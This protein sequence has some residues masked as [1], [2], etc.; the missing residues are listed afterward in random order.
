MTDEIRRRYLEVK[1][2]LFALADS[3]LNPAQREAVYDTEG[4]LLVFA[5]AGS[6]KTTVLVRRV[7]QIIRY[8]CGYRSEKVPEDVSLQT[9]EAY[10]SALDLS[11]EDVR[12][13]LDD[14]ADSPC[15]P[16]NMLAITF[17]NKAANEMK[18]RIEQMFPGSGI[19]GEIWAGTFHAVC[20]RILR[21]H[22][23]SAGLSPNVA[24][25]DADDSK[26]LVAKVIKELDIDD[27]QFQDKQVAAIISRAK[28][29]LTGPA[30]FA[31]AAKDSFREKTVARIY[32]EYQSR[33]EAANAVDFDDIIMKT[34]LA[35]RNDPD[36]LS[37]YARKFRYICVDEYQDTN[38]AQFELCSLLSSEWNNIMVVGDDDQ[39]IYRFRGATVENILSFE[40]TFPG[41][42]VVKLEQN[43]RSTSNILGAA[44]AVISKNTKRARKMLWTEKGA[45]IPIRVEKLPDG[46]S[47]SRRITEIIQSAVAG[48][49]YRYRDFAVLYRVN[50]Q[51]NSIERTFARSAVPYRIYG[52]Q[53]FNDRKEIKDV[54]AY[55]QLIANHSDAVRLRRIVNEPKRKIGDVTMDA[56]ERI[57]AETGDTVFGVMEHASRY[58]A[59]SRSA[60][61]LEGFCA[62]INRLTEIYASGSPLDAF[63]GTV[64]DMT[65]YRNMLIE[66]GEPERDRLENVEE[67]ISGAVEYM[68]NAP[69]P[70]LEGFLEENALVA[71]VDKY[72]ES[73][74]AVIMMTIH[75]AKGLEFP[76]VIIP[77]ME[78]GIFPSLRQTT[79]ESDI[80]EERRLCYVAITRAEK[81]LYMLYSES[82]MLYGKTAFN[83]PSRFLSDIP[84]EFCERRGRSSRD[85]RD[86]TRP[87]GE[88]KSPLFGTDRM[89]VGTPVSGRRIPQSGSASFSAGDRVVHP[90][91][92]GGTVLSVKKMGGDVL[93]EVAF[94]LFGTKKLMG[95]Y[96]RLKPE[97][98]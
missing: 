85:A 35:L 10:E 95:G 54:V 12:P 92:R 8:G 48:G 3:D 11:P 25:Y 84:D 41:A 15:P 68:E 33:L 69:E 5:G 87:F 28:E 34:V 47:E 70:T 39:S 86:Y 55:L 30:E 82:R 20:M 26:R 42:S 53:R 50:A 76:V 62:V 13:I 38:P 56:V 67:F 63:I 6:G 2:R 45:G 31:A 72:D 73:A 94:D 24:I 74:D 60:D 27:R 59:L 21:S 77:G 43:Y 89:T 22:P 57:A 71:D 90:T 9:V 29:R 19:S 80:E 97:E 78:D 83:L 64:L 58:T 44:N 1:K 36:L 81:E 91:F 14:F 65:G 52:G 37:I 66:G 23:A 40:K 7:A 17:T 16:R 75:S 49:R 51:A 98:N 4:P 61:K 96:A 18:S 79:E 32:A 93:Y 46:D 88:R